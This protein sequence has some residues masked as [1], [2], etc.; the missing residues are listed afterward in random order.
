VVF[1]WSMQI[2]P[3]GSKHAPKYLPTGPLGSTPW[4]A[5]VVDEAHRIKDGKTNR[6]RAVQALS[7]RLPDSALCLLLTGTPVMNRP[8]E[9]VPL[10]ST[11]GVLRPLFGSG[12]QF[13]QRYTD[14]DG[15]GRNLLELNQK[16]TGSVMIRRTREQVLHL[17][18]KNRRLATAAM[19]DEHRRA[20]KRAEDNL[21][22]Y[23]RDRRGDDKYTL[24]ER[25]E[26]IVLLNALRGVAGRGKVDAVAA[27]AEQLLAEGEQV[28]IAL[29]HKDV[30]RGLWSRLQRYGCV[31]VVGGMTGQQK[32][33]AVDAF[34]S[35]K[36]RVLLG[37]IEAAG[38]GITLTSGRHIIVAEL[39]WTPGALQQVEDR[40]HRIGQTRP[41]FSTL[42]LADW[43]KGSV[44]ERLWGLLQSKAITVNSIVDGDESELSV[45]G[46]EN[47]TDLLL[48]SYR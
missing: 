1:P 20:Y 22:E 36:A 23:L 6:S 3:N 2:D 4:A 47:I 28:F 38:V 30:E 13:M 42:V 19:S 16:L 11:L 17:P 48:N 7:R 5:L 40:L 31:S 12:A 8:G 25:A 34:Q 41:V 33:E 21:V 15:A 27:A 44:D 37:N 26:A 18:E 35:G 45:E 29:V 43:E 32:Q 10:L 14:Y 9:L 46:Q 39:P 24:S